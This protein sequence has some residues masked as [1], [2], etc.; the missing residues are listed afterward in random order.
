MG[1]KFLTRQ[2]KVQDDLCRSNPSPPRPQE[3]CQAYPPAVTK[4]PV[5]DGGVRA[6]PIPAL[7]SRNVDS[8]H[9]HL[10]CFLR[11]SRLDPAQHEILQRT[12]RRLDQEG[13]G[14]KSPSM[15]FRL[16][17]RQILHSDPF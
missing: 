15:M 6:S 3:G 10:G 5:R 17:S 9:L 1:D 4:L 7:E 14:L 12:Q 8:L 16:S 11:N 2:E 13:G